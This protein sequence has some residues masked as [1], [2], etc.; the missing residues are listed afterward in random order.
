MSSFVE[1]G[2]LPR[3]YVKVAADLVTDDEIRVV[4]LERRGTAV[5]MYETC[6]GNITL[7]LCGK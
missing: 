1:G 5:L 7:A 3:V 2:I 4:A 6:F